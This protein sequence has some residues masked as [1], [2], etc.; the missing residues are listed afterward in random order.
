MHQF[1]EA[2]RPVIFE[3][4]DS[5]FPYWGK[6][7]SLLLANSQSYFWITAGHVL[8]NMGG[9]VQ[10]LRIFP[11]DHSRISL[12]FNEQYTITKGLT[13]DEDYKDIFALRINI[14]EF[15]DFGDAP[16]IA[17]DADRGILPAE[18]LTL[19]DELWVIGY[20]AESNFID[21]DCGQIRNTRSVIR[22]IYRGP[23]VSDHCHEVRI[24]S[25]IHL[26]SYD[27][28]SGSPVFYMRSQVHDEQLV[29]SPLLVGM[30][31]RGTASSSLA[32]FVST[33]VISRIIS[34]TGNDA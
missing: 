34:L 24:E 16:L 4:E 11:S 2:S 14:K 29:Q 10:A 6:G 22:A 26:N 30:L 21:Y 5:K 9:S 12:P 33:S 23:S 19:G 20:P 31:L 15:E 3:Y 7:S 32:H 8:A 1:E 27:G 18:Q 17:Q 25:S 28:L 13:D